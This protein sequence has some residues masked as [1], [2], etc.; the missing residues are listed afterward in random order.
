MLLTRARAV[1][2]PR[3]W[4]FAAVPLA[5]WLLVSAV[6]TS[7]VLYLQQ[8]ARDA[9]VERFSAR[10]TLMRDFVVSY[11]ADLLERE[12]VQAGAFLTEATVSERDFVRS[13]GAFGYPSAVL[14]DQHGRVLQVAPPQPALIGTDLTGRYAHLRTAVVDG[15]PAVSGVVPS[16]ARGVPV[17]A[18]A[19]P[20]AAPSGRRV[21]SG[22]I[23]VGRSALSA[24]LNTAI[25][26]SGVRVQ[27]VDR[28][29]TVVA[30]NRALDPAAPTLAR[31]DRSLADAL[32]VRPAGRFQRDGTR[33][34]YTSQPIAGTPW[35]L[36]AA[37]SEPVLFA[38]LSGSEIAGR[39]AVS[40]A[41]AVGLLVVAATAKARRN[42]RALQLSEH[43]LRTMYDQ[44]RIGMLLT[45]PHGR[46][47][48][49]NPAIEQM[50]GRD[51]LVGR[52]VLDLLHPDDRTGRHGPDDLRLDGDRR[53]RHADGHVVEVSTTST[54]LHDQTGR[55]E[56]VATQVINV[57]AQR[58]LERDRQQHLTELAEHAAQLQRANTQVHDFMA[59]L[60]HD[61]RNPLTTV[62]TFGEI[63]LDDWDSVEEQ[64]RRQYVHRMT[65]A[66]HRAD[67][68]VTGVL[69]LAQLDA[70]ALVARPARLD[71]AH[72]IREAV[73]AHAATDG[74][75][76]GVTAPDQTIGLADPAH[77]QLI[78][79]NLLGNATKYG[80]PPVHVTVINAEETIRV[81][82]ADAGEGVPAA[83]VPSLFD[84]FTRAGSGV[85]TV[86]TGTGLGLYLAAQL[87]HAGGLGVSYTP[88]EPHGARFVLTIPRDARH[89]APRPARPV[90]R[91]APAP[92]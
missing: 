60:S 79:G 85:A 88:N 8:R 25:P 82:V 24:Y 45:D 19:V 69:T 81:E 32:R 6:G 58:A 90:P 50:L 68:L 41:A 89:S 39:V 70:G 55:T 2:S 61:V 63:L 7:G 56:Y 62:V 17:V 13:V 91:S 64:D 74:E 36:S 44:S 34:R 52:P 84:R 21:F 83:F 22:A 66:G 31:H 33:W 75:R 67:D 92:G 26:L 73:A 4:R 29:G 48:R 30:S 80:A 15:R 46:L 87:A 27:L 23:D 37:V 49:V 47:V 59:M 11:V 38:S 20:F 57:T 12:R 71:V 16:A 3:G 76:I 72:A 14:L 78:I 54:Y 18:F 9:A 5:V 10:A 42:R 53:F 51:D 65:A 43:R 1:L 35:R 28:D 40:T 77:L 86:K